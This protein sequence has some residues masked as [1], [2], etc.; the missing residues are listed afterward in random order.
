MNAG[1]WAAWWADYTDALGDLTETALELGMRE[2]V[3]RPDSRFMPKPGE[4]RELA[5]A[6]RPA[7]PT[8]FRGPAPTP[9]RPLTD[10]QFD[11]LSLHDKIWNHERMAQHEREL[12]GPQTDAPS[13]MSAKWHAHRARS[14]NHSAEARR[15][16][17]LCLPVHPA[18]LID[19]L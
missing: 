12:A 18:D 9:W 7:A 16:R 13:E 2:W 14:A 3:R 6:T 8:V 11:A 4:L 19:M 10:E 17:G 5:L 1:E 15:L